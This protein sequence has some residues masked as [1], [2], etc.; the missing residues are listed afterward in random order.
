MTVF[1]TGQNG[2]TGTELQRITWH[3]VHHVMTE[4]STGNHLPAVL[5]IP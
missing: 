2:L 3:V 5:G 1:E 4:Y